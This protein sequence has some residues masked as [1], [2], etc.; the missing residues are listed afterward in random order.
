MVVCHCQ[1][2]SDRIIRSHVAEGIATVEE[3][4]DRCGAGSLCGGCVPTIEDLL[5]CGSEPL[6]PRA[7]VSA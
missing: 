1:A 7:T 2:V 5:A 6:S 3:V 4:A